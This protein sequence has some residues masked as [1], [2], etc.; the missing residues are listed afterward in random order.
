MSADDLG[1]DIDG[2]LGDL[3]T[4]AKKAAA[5]KVPAKRAEPAPQPQPTVTEPEEPAV[6]DDLDPREEITASLRQQEQFTAASRPEQSLAEIKEQIR[7]E[8]MAEVLAEF[9]AEREKSLMQN[10]QAQLAAIGATHKGTAEDQTNWMALPAAPDD[11]E[12]P[13]LIHFVEDGFTINS[14]RAFRGQEYEPTRHDA[15]AAQTPGEQLKAYGRVMFR[16]GPWEGAS[17]D[18]DDPALTEEDRQRLAAIA[19]DRYANRLRVNPLVEAGT[20]R[21]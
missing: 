7:R 5:K 8:V 2:L 17:F 14:T 13:G 18:L 12:L 1:N 11:L 9:R 4:P 10:N 16:V 15:W 6:V 21:Y 3:N 19:Q 20:G